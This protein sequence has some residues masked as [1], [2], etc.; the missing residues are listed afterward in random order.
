MSVDVDQDRLSAEIEYLAQISDTA[1][2]SVTRILFTD[3]DMRARAWLRERFEEAG[4]DVR[5]DAV[6]N[7][8]G[9]WVGDDPHAA[10]VATGSHVDAIPDAGRFDGVIGVLGGRSDV[11]VRKAFCS[12]VRR[13][14]SMPNRSC[15]ARPSPRRRMS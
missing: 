5:V 8:F 13:R 12:L 10:P 15:S 11:T 1:Y 4:L 9:R 2:P 3:T 7:M 14:W 6:G